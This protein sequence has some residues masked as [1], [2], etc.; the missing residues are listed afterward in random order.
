MY[1]Y[2]HSVL[3]PADLLAAAR[4]SSVCRYV[5]VYVYMVTD[6]SYTKGT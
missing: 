5:Y 2:V 4:P 6:G 3:E 1:I